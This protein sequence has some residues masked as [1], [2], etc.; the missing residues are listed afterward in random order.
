MKNSN[1]ILKI[2]LGIV[3]FLISFNVFAST[4]TQ[5]CFENTDT[6]DH[7]VTKVE[8]EAS[9]WNPANPEEQW[10]GVTIP[11]GK[12]VCKVQKVAYNKLPMGFNNKV[13]FYFD[14]DLENY[15]SIYTNSTLGHIFYGYVL[16][17]INKDNPKYSYLM[18]DYPRM[19][20]NSDSASM[21]LGVENDYDN[22]SSTFALA[23][24]RHIPEGSY[25]KACK[26]WSFVNGVIDAD[27]LYDSTDYNS[28][29]FH[30]TLD[31]AKDCMP[32]TEV[33]VRGWG[34]RTGT[35]YCIN[36]VN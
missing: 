31:Y 10:Q 27:C 18:A 20:Y 19:S 22:N 2:A 3:G 9:D 34:D 6:I 26:I 11:S 33:G 35:L 8:L 17:I 16:D 30:Q 12:K 1:L 4:A 14:N 21:A 32:G 25:K 28:H 5:L 7:T 36:P 13:N 15:T 24:Y 29:Y 23:D